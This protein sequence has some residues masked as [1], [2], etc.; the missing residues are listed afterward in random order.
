MYE[1]FKVPGLC[2]LT[3][4]LLEEVGPLGSQALEE[5]HFVDFF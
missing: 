3:T 2:R 4:V 5:G 1:P